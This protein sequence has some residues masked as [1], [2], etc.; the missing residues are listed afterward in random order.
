[1]TVDAKAP[2]S[3]LIGDAART[4]TASQIGCVLNDIA[5]TANQ[6]DILVIRLQS[7]AEDPQMVDALAG[8][9]LALAQRIGWAADMAADRISGSGGM[10]FGDAVQWMMPPSFN[11]DDEKGKGNG[12]DLTAG[13]QK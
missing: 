5:A 11:W 12:A 8:A 6:I 1:M 7:T 4:L 3:R 10:A 9:V 13:A 2:E